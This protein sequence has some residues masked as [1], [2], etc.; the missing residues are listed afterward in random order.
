MKKLVLVIAF[1]TSAFSF[2][3]EKSTE[4]VLERNLENIA[5]RNQEVKIT[6]LTDAEKLRYCYT[7]TTMVATGNSYVGMDGNSYTEYMVTERT[8]CITI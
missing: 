4:I 1:M 8:S 7:T 5:V 2:A 3:S 6:S